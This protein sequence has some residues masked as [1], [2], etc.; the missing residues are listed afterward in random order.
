[1]SSE[2]V[3]YRVDADTVAQIEIEPVAGFRPAGAADLAG[4]VKESA[5][6]VVAAAR[7]LLD[8]VRQAAPDSVQVKFGIKVT[9]TANWVLAKAATEANFEVTMIWKPDGPP[10]RG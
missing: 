3:R 2:V 10:G 8:E 6:P 1:M 7:V 9:G 5:A 4:T